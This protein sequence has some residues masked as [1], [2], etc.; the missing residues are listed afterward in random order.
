VYDYPQLKKDID[1]SGVG[2]LELSNTTKEDIKEF[3]N[4]NSIKNLITRDGTL[5]LN[6]TIGMAGD[7][8]EKIDDSYVAPTIQWMYDKTLVTKLKEKIVDINKTM[9]SVWKN[10][11]YKDIT[12]RENIHTPITR[13]KVTKYSYETA[14]DTSLWYF[15]GSYEKLTILRKWLVD[16]YKTSIF[17]MWYEIP[18]QDIPNPVGVDA[19]KIHKELTKIYLELYKDAEEVQNFGKEYNSNTLRNTALQQTFR[20]QVYEEGCFI[21]PHRDSDDLNDIPEG[22]CSMLLYTNEDYVEGM[23]GELVCIDIRPGRR[24]KEIT[25]PPTIGTLVIVDFKQNPSHSVNVIKE[26]NWMRTTIGAWWPAGV[27]Y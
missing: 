10:Y 15:D 14:V 27:E 21:S 13:D 16:N 12:C 11:K 17:Q 19:S 9:D 20:L 2:I 18:L 3:F 6:T 4:K 1:N 7:M 5:F 26:K 22:N 23:G 25:V 24:K 8:G